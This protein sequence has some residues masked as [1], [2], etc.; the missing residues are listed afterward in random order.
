[1]MNLKDFSVIRNIFSRLNPLNSFDFGE[2]DEDI[3]S[4]PISDELLKNVVK[5]I[6]EMKLQK[7]KTFFFYNNFLILFF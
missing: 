2:V 3:N 1:M 7:F 6:S 5:I 4:P